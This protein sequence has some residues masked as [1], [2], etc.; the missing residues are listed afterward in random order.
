MT[1]SCN[2]AYESFIHAAL[3]EHLQPRSIALTPIP[4]VQDT[5]VYA[6]ATDV[7]AFIF[8]TMDPSGRDP[9]GTAH[10]VGAPQPIGRWQ[11]LN[12]RDR[13]RWKRRRTWGGA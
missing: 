9:D 7:G 6:V 3:A 4:T 11:F 1:K 13:R 2:T 8:K 5:I 10:A 12:R